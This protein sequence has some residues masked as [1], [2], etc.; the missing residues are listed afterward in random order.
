MLH[1]TGL[2][3]IRDDL[4]TK[5]QQQHTLKRKTCMHPAQQS[6]SH[7]PLHNLLSNVSISD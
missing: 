7:C 6:Q 5:Q 3:S 1:S 2:K 4:A